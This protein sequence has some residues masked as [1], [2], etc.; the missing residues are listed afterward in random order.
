MAFSKI[1]AT[2]LVVLA[3][4]SMA[5]GQWSTVDTTPLLAGSNP[6]EQIQP[7]LRTI[8]DGSVFVSFF[9]NGVTNVKGDTWTWSGTAWAK[10]A[11]VGPA[12]RQGH[13]MA[14]DAVRQVT[15]LFGGQGA[16]GAVNDT[17]EWNGTSWAS[18]TATGPVAAYGAMA[19]DAARAQV[20]LFG[21]TGSGGLVNSTWAYTASGWTQLNP[22]ASPSA[23]ERHA[24][25][26]DSVRNVIVLF[27]GDSTAGREGDTWEFDGTNWV[28]AAPAASPPARS[29]GVMAFDP[30]TNRI[31]MF[32]GRDASNVALNDTWSYDGTTWT[33][34]VTATNP[35]AR[36]GHAMSLSNTAS[37]QRLVTFGGNSGTFNVGN[38][39]EFS[40][41]NWASRTSTPTSRNNPALAF[42]AARNNTVLFGGV[43][44][45]GYD[46][47]AQKLNTRGFRQWGPQGVVAADRGVSSTVDYD[48]NVDS[49]GNA[50]VAYNDDQAPPGTSQQ[51]SVAKISPAGSVLWRQTLTTGTTAKNNPKVSMLSDGNVM[52]GWSGQNNFSLVKLDPNGATLWAGPVTVVD[53]SNFYMALSD[54]QPSDNGSVIALWVRGSGTS[55]ITSAKGL[56]MQKY[57]ATGAPVWNSGAPRIVFPG[58][59]GAGGT[60]IQNG[61]FPTFVSDGA[62]GAVI[63]WYETSGSRNAYIQHVL[64][65]GALKFAA[66]VANTGVTAGRIRVG[67]GLAYTPSDGAYFLASPE[68]NSGSQSL[69][70][71]FVQKFDAS[72]ARLWGD[73][74]VTIVPQGSTQQG[75]VNCVALP[76]GGALVAFLDTRSATTRVVS[77]ARVRP[78]QSTAWTIN[79][80]SDSSTDKGRLAAAWSSAGFAVV[81]YQVGSSG[82]ADLA[83]Q[84]INLDGTLGYVCRADFDNNTVL[85]VS[86]IFSFL[87][88]WFAGCQ[89][90]AGAPCNGLNAD[91]NA[92]GALEVS[93]IFT[94]LAL[95]FA[96][97]P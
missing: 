21:G 72:G 44:V 15:V 10:S 93:D 19:Y 20:V 6:S 77:A 49:S 68:T 70:S 61:Y 22:A 59:S 79:V 31:V 27:G 28:Q 84:N 71:T 91:I 66:P 69:N 63:G 24:L 87:G 64:A 96:G 42:D 62:G 23:R 4:T 56:W 97:C 1:V 11:A 52:V 78:D 14:Y 12:A 41:T 89:G 58:V 82:V 17:W 53:A 37:G 73:T 32:G 25:A 57:D 50:Y 55:A 67:A 43:D 81:A 39:F 5:M 54:M 94:F 33:Q 3:G 9:D 29:G 16:T 26:Y 18:T 80:N 38:L 60:S 47:V 85:E 75:F 65:S 48:M 88:A 95:W 90:A 36:F 45:G 83:V 7:K 51:I 40:G 76:D 74:G 35:T 92:S 2:T 30:V 86:D 13:V 8:A 46:P 34:A